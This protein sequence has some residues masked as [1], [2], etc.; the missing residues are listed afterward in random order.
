MFYLVPQLLLSYF[1]FNAGNVSPWWCPTM[2]AKVR[3]LPGFCIY[4]EGRFKTS[5][6][7]WHLQ[8]QK[9]RPIHHFG[10]YWHCF[11]PAKSFGLSK[12]TRFMIVFF[13]KIWGHFSSS[14]FINPISTS[15]FAFCCCSKN[16]LPLDENHHECLNHLF[17]RRCLDFSSIHYSKAHLLYHQQKTIRIFVASHFI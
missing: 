4:Q 15:G 7:I 11:W 10:P 12:S 14:R 5:R 17:V 3:R 9:D 6:C 13:L 1:L 2:V 8:D 16:V